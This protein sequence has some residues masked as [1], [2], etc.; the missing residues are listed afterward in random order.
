M[1]LRTVLGAGNHLRAKEDA[2]R[3]IRSGGAPLVGSAVDHS[4][5]WSPA[6]SRISRSCLGV[7]W[8]AELHSL[9]QVEDLAANLKIEA[10]GERNSPEQRE[11]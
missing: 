10:F 6:Q 8:R 9:E 4:V 3:R 1:G 11:F 7:V 2:Y 5:S